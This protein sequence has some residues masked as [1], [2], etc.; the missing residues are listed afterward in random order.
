MKSIGKILPTAL[1]REVVIMAKALETMK[2]WEDIVG[3]ELASRSW[4]DR[5][6]RG[7]VWVAV[8]GSA[9]AQE[10]RLKKELILRRLNELGGQGSLFTDV[11]FGVRKLPVRDVPES[12]VA[13]PEEP[14]EPLTIR[15]IANR[16]LERWKLDHPD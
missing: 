8:T 9:W 1:D 6:D 4:P 13:V 3:V 14:K 10:L 2:R 12:A 11:R 5:F 16:R 15:E 7:T